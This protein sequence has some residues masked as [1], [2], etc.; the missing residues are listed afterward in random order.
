[1]KTLIFG[2]LALAGLLLV[3]LQ[4]QQIGR[5]HAENAALQQASAEADQ[6]KADLAKSTGNE[7]AEAE[8]IEQLKEENRGLL[9]LRN[10]VSQLR[11]ARVQFEKV[12]AENQRLQSAV[13]SMPKADAKQTAMQPIVVRIQD[14]SYRG[15]S[16]PEAAMQTFLWAEREG[17]LNVLS[18]CVAP[19]QR[20][21]IREAFGN[22][23][24][25]NFDNVVSIEIVARRE[26]NATTVQLGIQ[27]HDAANPQF[28]QRLI[29]TLVLQGSD[30]RVDTLS[31]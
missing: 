11:A 29:V 4:H 8:E 9:K 17:N 28:G 31:Q 30:W 1:M 14:L 13:R 21:R 2:S 6:L 7:A 3:G 15:L 16:T 24:R 25:Q 18:E 12:S 23:P 22:N 26:V 5:L 27:F 10:E 19:E 20:S